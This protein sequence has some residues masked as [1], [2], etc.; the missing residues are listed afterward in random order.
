MASALREGYL[1]TRMVHKN[2]EK[3]TG[4]VTGGSNDPNLY[5]TVRCHLEFFFQFL[6]LIL[7]GRVVNPQR[8]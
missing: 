5:L 6:P 8:S 3:L 4:R 1:H 2:P 7:V